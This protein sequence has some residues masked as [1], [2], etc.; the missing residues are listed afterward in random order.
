MV[1]WE[2]RGREHLE[3]VANGSLMGAQRLDTGVLRDRIL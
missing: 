3:T 1:V 2:L